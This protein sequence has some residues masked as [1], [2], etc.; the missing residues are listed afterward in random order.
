M[1]PWTSAHF[2]SLIPA[3]EVAVEDTELWTGGSSRCR[4]TRAV[5]RSGRPWASSHCK[6]QVQP[7]GEGSCAPHAADGWGMWGEH[8][9]PKCCCC[10]PMVKQ[11]SQRFAG[12]ACFSPVQVRHTNWFVPQQRRQTFVSPG[13]AYYA[14]ISINLL[15]VH[16]RETQGASWR[17]LIEKSYCQT[18]TASRSR[19]VHLC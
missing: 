16:R 4:G 8:Q 2:L 3:W 17:C 6:A 13:W 5:C 7:W 15:P 14:A 12:Q 11:H 10:F 9:H 18:T 19:Y 1:K